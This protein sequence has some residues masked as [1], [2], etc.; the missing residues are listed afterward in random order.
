MQATKSSVDLERGLPLALIRIGRQ[1][2]AVSARTPDEA[3]AVL[4]LHRVKENGPCRMSE[5]AGQVG[6]D[7]STV[8][9]H[10][11]RLARDG[12]V[13]RSD[14]PDDRRAARLVLTAKGRRR[15]ASATQ[16]RNDLIHA[17]VA[18]WSEEELRTLSALTERLAD[19]L[20]TRTA[21]TEGR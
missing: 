19:A 14:D 5:L 7:T 18:D 4:L 16:A 1:L 2:K 3:W 8:S 12:Y 13:A 6:L 11:A 21:R 15:L 9:R 17:A 10:V 20:D